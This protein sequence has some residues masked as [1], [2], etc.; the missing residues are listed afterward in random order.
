MASDREVAEM[1]RKRGGGF[2]S[3]LG[4]AFALADA[5]NS[6]KIKDTWSEYWERYEAMAD[7]EK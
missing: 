2:V 3:K 1:M 6:K 4:E 7:A 5:D